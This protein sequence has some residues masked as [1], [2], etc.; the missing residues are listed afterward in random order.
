[1]LVALLLD[2]KDAEKLV[3]HFRS[4]IQLFRNIDDSK[5]FSAVM[6]NLS[7]HYLNQ[8]DFKKALANSDSSIVFA[9]YSLTLGDNM[10]TSLFMA[11]NS[12]VE[13]YKQM[14]QY[15]SA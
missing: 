10:S 2:K 4:A 7:R 1:M 3:Y 6:A 14:G 5:G 8:M 13:L 11:Y 9:T 12:R 15:D